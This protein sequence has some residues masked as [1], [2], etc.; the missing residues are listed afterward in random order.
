MLLWHGDR[1]LSVSKRAAY[2]AYLD[3]PRLVG[4]PLEL[5]VNLHPRDRTGSGPA[6]SAIAAPVTWPLVDR[7]SLKTPV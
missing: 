2:L 7:C 1:V 6:G 5:A 4:R 3:L